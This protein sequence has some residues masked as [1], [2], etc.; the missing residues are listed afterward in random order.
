MYEGCNIGIDGRCFPVQLYPM[1]IREFD[2]V[3]GMDWLAG[4]NASIECKKKMIVVP[5][6]DGRK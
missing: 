4:V 3:F 5:L 1:G 2:V 6:E